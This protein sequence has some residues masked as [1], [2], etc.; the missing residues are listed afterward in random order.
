[1]KQFSKIVILAFLIVALL[2]VNVFAATNTTVADGTIY[3]EDGSY[4]TVTLSCKDSRATSSKTASRTY[5]YYNSNDVEQWRAVL[6]GSFTYTGSTSSCTSSSCNV[7]ITNTN[8]YVVSKT[9]SKSGSSAT[10]DLTMGKKLLG[11]TVSK[12]SISMK[13]TCD[14]NGNLS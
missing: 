13:L 1:M 12:K 9:A 14:A 4:I 10:A 3:L 8:W 6:T 11:I 2:P 5:T 7:T